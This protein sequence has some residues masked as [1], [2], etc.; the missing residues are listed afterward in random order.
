MSDDDSGV[1]S[2]VHTRATRTND[3]LAY[4]IFGTLVALEIA[5]LALG[6]ETTLLAGVVAA[7]VYAV[8]VMLPWAFGTEAAET[9]AE[10]MTDTNPAG[11]REEDD[12]EE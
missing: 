8:Y 11:E 7:H 9:G 12:E 6:A 5:M 10:M 4:I 3:K 2:D 1:T